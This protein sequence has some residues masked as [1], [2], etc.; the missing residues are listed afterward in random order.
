[1]NHM[2]IGIE[3]LKRSLEVEDL[4][5]QREALS[6]FIDET[7]DKKVLEGIRISNEFMMP[8]SSEYIVTSHVKE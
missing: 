4:E 8:E 3:E 6:K 7:T 2:S 5:E 1:V